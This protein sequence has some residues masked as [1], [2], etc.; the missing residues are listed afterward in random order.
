MIYRIAILLFITTVCQAQK[1]DNT[2]VFKV[3]SKATQCKIVCKNSFFFL[4]I[5]NPIEIKL[6]GRNK[7][8]SVEVSTGG[9]VM[10]VEKDTYY[11][12]FLRPGAAVI[13]VYLYTS[14][15]KKLIAIKMQEVRSPEIFFCGIKMDS[16]SRSIKLNGTNFYAFSSY[17]KQ[18]MP[19]AS[20]DMYYV[21]DTLAKKIEPIKMKSDTCMLSPEMRKRILSFQPKKNYIYFHNIICTVPDGSKRILD[22]IE[23]NVVVDTSNKE[24]LSLMYSV[25]RKKD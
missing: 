12:R 11:I 14:T 21:D 8:I 10:S 17:F 15:G 22:P 4:E 18:I 3:R 13:S 20:F 2:V 19:M 23:L 16:S 7:N 9:K 24:K 25:R 1:L 6:K 5:N